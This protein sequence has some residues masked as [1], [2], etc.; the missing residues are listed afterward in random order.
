MS[1]SADT[2]FFFSECFKKKKESSQRS[3]QGREEGKKKQEGE[4]GKK[5]GKS[6]CLDSRDDV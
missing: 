2:G 5:R 1:F 6:K 3:K 4:K